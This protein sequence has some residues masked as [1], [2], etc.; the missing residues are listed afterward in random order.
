MTFLDGLS[1][2]PHETPGISPGLTSS[3]TPGMRGLKHVWGSNPG[4]SP[5]FETLSFSGVKNEASTPSRLN[6]KELAREGT[7][8]PRGQFLDLFFGSYTYVQIH[9]MVKKI[10][11]WLW[12]TVEKR[13]VLSKMKLASP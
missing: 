10:K 13:C 7:D 4:V 5:S 1:L 9:D 12:K 3:G 8:S 6:L 11:E 2:K